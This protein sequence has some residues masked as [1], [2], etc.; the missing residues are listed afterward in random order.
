MNGAFSC[1]LS[2]LASC[3]S[4]VQRNV[5][6]FLIWGLSIN[7]NGVACFAGNDY[8]FVCFESEC[9]LYSLFVPSNHYV[10]CI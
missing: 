7:A 8:F 5:V 10:E 4:P 6:G 2:A 3:I 1:C 9:N